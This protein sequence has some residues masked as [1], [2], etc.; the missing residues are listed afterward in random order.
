MACGGLGIRGVFPSEP[1]KSSMQASILIRLNAFFSGVVDGLCDPRRRRRVML[2]IVT[3]YGA[4]WLVYGVVAKSSQDLNG[5]L[6][7]MV[8]GDTSPPS[9]IPSIRR[10]W[11]MR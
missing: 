6:A 3:A 8:V 10:Y 11:L 1:I 9:V 5:D 4:A 2:A 7:E